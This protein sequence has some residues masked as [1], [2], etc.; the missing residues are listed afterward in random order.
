M[1]QSAVREVKCSPCHR[2]VLQKADFRLNV[3]EGVH[4]CVGSQGNRRG[5]PGE[6]LV[7]IVGC[8]RANGELDEKALLPVY[9]L[10]DADSRRPTWEQSF[11]GP[12][13]FLQRFAAI[14]QHGD[15]QLF[16]DSPAA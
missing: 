13:A 3:G 14:I 2:R 6:A 11:P 7:R 15:R 8:V 16:R 12:P 4:F 1:I 5:R 9:T 10:W